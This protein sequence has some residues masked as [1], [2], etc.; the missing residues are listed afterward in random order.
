M[1]NIIIFTDCDFDDTTAIS[2]LLCQHIQ[3]KIMILGIVCEDGF[4]TF[5]DNICWISKWLSL[6]KVSGIPIIKG[7]PP[8][9]YLLKERKFPKNWILSYKKMLIEKYNV[10]FREVPPYQDLETFLPM[11]RN[12]TFLVNLLGPIRS[13]G[14]LLREFCNFRNMR[15][16]ATLGNLVEDGTSNGPDTTYN[17]FLDPDGLRD[18][19]LFSKCPSL[20]FNATCN[21]TT[22][23]KIKLDFYRREAKKYMLHPDIAVQ[24]KFVFNKTMQFLQY[25]LDNESRDT[26]LKLWD[27]ITTFL[28]LQYPMGQKSIRSKLLVSWTGKT[29]IESTN[30]YKKSCNVGEKNI[31]NDTNSFV[32]LNGKD[33]DKQFVMRFFT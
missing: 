5:P 32:K 8:T 11:I 15:S 14:I 13:Y 22:F 10:D 9:R 12:T 30:S 6:N 18:Y 23:D 33:F 2:I 7:L 3:K 31:G 16:N 24:L 29:Q 27:V 4:L 26:D 25:F 20:V 17:A 19:L 28:L 1:E 21:D